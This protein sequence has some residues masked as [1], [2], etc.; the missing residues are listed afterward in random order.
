MV[1]ALYIMASYFMFYGIS[2]YTNVCVSVSIFVSCVFFLLLFSLFV[3]LYFSLFSLYLILIL[4]VYLF[5]SED[6]CVWFCGKVEMTGRIAGGEAIIRT[7]EIPT[8][9]SQ[10]SDSFTTKFYQTLIKDKQPMFSNYLSKINRNSTSRFFLQY[11]HYSNIKT[12]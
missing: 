11:H 12:G 3:L 9:K 2:V 7:N 5:S 8:N 4:D 6:V 10:N 1:F